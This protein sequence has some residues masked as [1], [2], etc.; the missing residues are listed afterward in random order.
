MPRMIL[1][2]SSSEVTDAIRDAIARWDPEAKEEACGKMRGPVTQFEF[3][4]R[5][6]TRVEDVTPRELLPSWYGVSKV[7]VVT[8]ESPKTG[9]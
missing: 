5:S 2:M 6:D 7:E 4:C 1:I 9:N 3:G 8:N